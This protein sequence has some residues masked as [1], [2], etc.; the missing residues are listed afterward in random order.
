M[1]DSFVVLDPAI[2]LAGVIAIGALVAHVALRFRI[3]VMLSLS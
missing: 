1:I 2:W 3:S